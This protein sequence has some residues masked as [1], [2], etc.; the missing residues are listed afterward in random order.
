MILQKSL[1]SVRLG[2]GGTRIYEMQQW[3]SCNEFYVSFA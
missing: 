3:P 2:L 1:R